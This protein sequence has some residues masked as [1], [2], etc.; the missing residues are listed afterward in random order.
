M[1]VFVCVCVCVSMCVSMH[2]NVCICLYL[3]VCVFTRPELG[4]SRVGMLWGGWRG[5]CVGVCV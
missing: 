2:V 1:Y 4:P 5:L 3:C